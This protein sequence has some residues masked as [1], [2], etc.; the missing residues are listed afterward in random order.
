MKWQAS[1]QRYCPASCAIVT[2]D[3]VT[4]GNW[5]RAQGTPWH[6][7]CNLLWF[8]FKT[9]TLHTQVYT[10]TSTHTH[11][12]T[13][14]WYTIIWIDLKYIILNKGSEAQKAAC[15]LKDFILRHSGKGKS[16]GPENRSVIFQGLH[17]R[18][19]GG[20][21][22]DG[23]VLYPDCCGVTWIYTCVKTYGTIHQKIFSLF[24]NFKINIKK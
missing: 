14:T 7:L 24:V 4:G 21:W 16:L 23:T 11:T 5:L 9:K 3:G 2:W 10:H 6:Y 18:Q 13:H 8:Y 15:I 12:H 20:V 1:Y 17:G 19:Q 22:D